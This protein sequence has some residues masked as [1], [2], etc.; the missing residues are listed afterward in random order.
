MCRR[1]FQR[2]FQRIHKL[3]DFDWLSQI[4]EKSSLQASLDVARHC[5]GAESNHWDVGGR[6]IFVKDFESFETAD[7]GKIDIH[8][9]YVRKVG[10]CKT[11]TLISVSGAQQPYIRTP[12][13]QLLDQLQ[14]RRVVLYIEQRAPRR[15]AW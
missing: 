12:C 1:E 14:I 3:I 4:L 5:V 9:N 13:D 2:D 15:P 7:S 8:E 6:R 11:N 10:V